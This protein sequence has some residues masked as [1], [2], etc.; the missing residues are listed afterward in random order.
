MRTTVD[1][2]NPRTYAVLAVLVVLSAL[3]L[4]LI[5]LSKGIWLDEWLSIRTSGSAD[6]MGALRSYDHPPLYFVLLRAWSILGSD[7]ISGATNARR[8]SG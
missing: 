7:E 2:M 8:R 5:G 4:R 1:E 3:A 6:L